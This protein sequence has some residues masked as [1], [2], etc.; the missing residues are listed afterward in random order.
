MNQ[1][2]SAFMLTA[3]SI[4]KIQPFSVRAVIFVLLP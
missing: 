1:H 4:S 3:E 2:H